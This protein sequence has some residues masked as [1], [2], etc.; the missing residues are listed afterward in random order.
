MAYLGSI[1]PLDVLEHAC[2]TPLIIE[3][4]VLH[5]YPLKDWGYPFR[6]APEGGGQNSIPEADKTFWKTLCRPIH[7]R[8]SN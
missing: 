6:F 1:K 7:L 5:T 8:N 2:D 3:V 4:F